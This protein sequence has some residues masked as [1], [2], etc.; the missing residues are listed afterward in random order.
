MVNQSLKG[1]FALRG[2]AQ[3]IFHFKLSMLKGIIFHQLDSFPLGQVT[4][5]NM[6][7]DDLEPQLEYKAGMGVV[8]SFK[9]GH[10]GLS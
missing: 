8:T 5:Q 10:L 9:L 6:N 4:F 3:I 2:Q 1:L 7:P